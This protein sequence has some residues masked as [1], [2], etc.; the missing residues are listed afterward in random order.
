MSWGRAVR[1]V[2]LVV[3]APAPLLAPAGSSRQLPPV[4]ISHVTVIDVT[5]A[6]PSS[7]MTVVVTGNRITGVGKTG[8][9]QLP[10]AARLVDARGKFLIPGLW[11]MHVHTFNNSSRPG[12]DNSDWYF[13]LLIANG[14]TGLRDMWTD[15]EDIRLTRAWRQ[16]IDSGTLVGPRFAVSSSVVDGVP[17]LLK[18]A[19]GV[20]TPDEARRAV[21]TL[22]DA[23]AGFIKVYWN[24]SPEAYH[25]VA[26]EAKRLGIPFAGHVPFSMSAADVS[27]A[28][29]RSIE[30]L[31]GVPETCSSRDAE[32]RKVRDWTPE[33]AEEMWRTY[34][35]N[36]CRALFARFA[37][38]G[39]WHTP[40]LVLRRALGFRTDEGLRSDSRLRY[41]PAGV[42]QDWLRPLPDEDAPLDP[43]VRA[44]RFRR[45]IAIVAGMHRAGVPLLA[46]SDIGNPFVFPG[47][48]LH[49]ELELFVQAGLTPLE[50]LQAATLNPA[51]YLGL[52]GSLATIE[53]G[54]LADLVLLDANP[55]EDIG[56]TRRIAAV[57]TNGRYL[58][59]D[60]LETML[61][62]VEAGAKTK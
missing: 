59:R 53:E 21:R 33:L 28:G 61:A 52:T 58:P 62:D 44:E 39:T 8:R 47:F 34:D 42:A 24:L 7:D 37:R 10:K 26:D 30:H 14:V 54:K 38:N 16:E 60:V 51:R 50:A 22:K 46:G 36:K 23:G 3:F 41:V 11:D 4:A 29:Q 5:G 1:A 17:T 55:L 57:V 12:T 25:A 2:S 19:I 49:D 13:P 27:D 15:P 31:T 6:A 45:L 56:H 40:T 48:S 35:E 9:V 18:N 32:L 43:K 20:S